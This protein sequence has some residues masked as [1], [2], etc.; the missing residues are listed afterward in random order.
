MTPCINLDYLDLMSDGDA[1]MKKTML[2]MLLEELPEEIQKLWQAYK[3]NDWVD[4][5]GISHKLKSTLSFVGNE[6]MT[7]ANKKI[8]QYAYQQS[9]LDSIPKFI[10]VLDNLYPS[11]AKALN[12]EAAR[13]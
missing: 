12:M 5:R 3:I 4:L 7:E 10:T 1:E 11:V 13:L 8:E 9:N 6:A 2:L